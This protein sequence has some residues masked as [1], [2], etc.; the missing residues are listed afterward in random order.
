M[1]FWGGLLHSVLLHQLYYPSRPELVF[2]FSGST[3]TFGCR[4]FCIITGLPNV[5]GTPTVSTLDLPPSSNRLLRMYGVA[6]QLKRF[7]LHNAFVGC[8]DKL[9]QVKLGVAYLVEGLIFAK[10]MS[11]FVRHEILHLVDDV[12]AFNTVAWGKLS[13]EFMSPTLKQCLVNKRKTGLRGTYAVKGFYDALS[14]WAMEAI[15]ELA[16]VG[17]EKVGEKFPR[18]VNWNMG[19]RAAYSA[20]MATVFKQVMSSYIKYFSDFGY[21]SV[22]P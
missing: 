6:G 17:A 3:L 20:L 9:D 1:G 16:K 2:E 5:G 11:I 4:E 7:E 18:M 10:A 14:V 8:K 19:N 22:F 21:F 15:P 12:A 13:W